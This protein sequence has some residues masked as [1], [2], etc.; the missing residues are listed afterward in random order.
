MYTLTL[1]SYPRTQIVNTM[2][3]YTIL[4]NKLLVQQLEPHV[5]D[6]NLLNI[7]FLDEN[8]KTV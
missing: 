2:L 3:K 8:E 6:L 4:S 5:K 7:P 1:Y